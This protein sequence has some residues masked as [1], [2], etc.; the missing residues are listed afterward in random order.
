MTQIKPNDPARSEALRGL[1]W[2]SLLTLVGLAILIGL[3]TWQLGRKAEKDALIA[4]LEARSQAS[5]T[6]LDDALAKWREG[7]VEYLRV[8]VRGVLDH[9]KE[10]YLYE[11]HKRYGAGYDVFAPLLVDGGARYVWVNIGYVPEQLRDPAS[12]PAGAGSEDVDLTGIVRLSAK[13]GTF[14]PDNDVAGNQWYWRD[15]EGMHASAF[16]PAQT[17]LIPFFLEAEPKPEQSRDEWP[18][19]GASKVTIVNRHFEYALTWY[20]LALTL[21]AVYVAFAAGRLTNRRDLQ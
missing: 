15:L 16:D 18:K 1:L 17:E 12:R 14:T 4:S 20:G 8:K 7:D 9:S 10:R 5:P 3:G 6:S 2:P 19:P 11:P 13:P 21:I